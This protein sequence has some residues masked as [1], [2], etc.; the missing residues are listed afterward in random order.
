MQH[1]HPHLYIYVH[2]LQSQEFLASGGGFKTPT[3]LMDGGG[4]C[5]PFQYP[6]TKVFA[7]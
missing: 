2:V 7:F 5:M 3:F 6:E 1:A 4:Y